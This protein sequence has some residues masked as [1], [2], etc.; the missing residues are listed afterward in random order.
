MERAHRAV[1]TGIHG[2]QKIECFGTAHFADDYS[3]RAHTQAVL[4]QVAHGNL[5]FA[6]DIGR[7]RFQ[8]HRVRL[9]Q[10][11]FGSV[12]AGDDAFVALDELRQTVQERCLA[13][14]RTTRH[15]DVRTAAA[16][17]AKDFG[18]FRRDTAKP[19]KLI[20]CKF[21]LLELSNGQYRPVDRERGRDHV[22]TR[23]VCQSCVA[24]RGRFIDAPSD[25]TDNS[26]ANVQ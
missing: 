26:L 22:D 21:V 19:Y 2:L 18:A 5:A 8:P 10:L 20:E 16:N 4:D 3:F 24:D 1:V 23:A 6:L 17:Y 15:N 14:T 25:L 12:L 7:T 13:G 11:Q 9:L